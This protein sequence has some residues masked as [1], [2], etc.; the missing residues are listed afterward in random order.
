MQFVFTTDWEG[1]LHCDQLSPQSGPVTATKE[2][3]LTYE[4]QIGK[5][6]MVWC[7]VV[8]MV[9]CVW[10]SVVWCSVYGVVCMVWC[11]WYGVVCMVWCGVYGVA[12]VLKPFMCTFRFGHVGTGCTNCFQTCELVQVWLTAMCLADLHILQEVSFPLPSFNWTHTD[13]AG[14]VAALGEGHCESFRQL[15]LPGKSAG[16]QTS[17]TTP[18]S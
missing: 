18:L 13:E 14:Q 1:I 9:W 11:V 5:V 7:G 15:P 16:P 10:C 8:C 17:I 4:A 2:A 6:C 12:A 3:E